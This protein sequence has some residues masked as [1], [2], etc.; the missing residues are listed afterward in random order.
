MLNILRFLNDGWQFD[1]KVGYKN[2]MLIKFLS[3]LTLLSLSA[4]LSHSPTTPSYKKI[5]LLPGFRLRSHF[6]CS[7]TLTR[8]HYSLAIVTA[9]L[10]S[11]S[12]HFSLSHAISLYSSD[13]TLIDTVNKMTN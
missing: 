9:L 13:K 11:P 7:G 1:E 8:I 2:F 3:L 10:L 5:R 4:S 12:H 6:R